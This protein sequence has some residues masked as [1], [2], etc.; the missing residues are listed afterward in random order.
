MTGTTPD[1]ATG[2]TA[3]TDGATPGPLD[4]IRVVDL[5]SV[6]MGPYAARI[7]GDLGAEVVKI[8]PPTGDVMRQLH[9]R[10][11]NGLGALMLNLNRNK[12]SAALDLKSP[13]GHRAALDIIA[14]ADVLITNMRPR[15]LKKLGLTYDDLAEAN[16]RLVYCQAAGFRAD[17]RYADRAAYDEVIQSTSGM[18]DLM[19]RATGKPSY[20]PTVLADKVCGLAIVQGVMAALLARVRTG[21]G[22]RVEVPMADTMFA[23]TLLEHIGGRAFEP[24]HGDVGFPR[25]LAPG[26]EALPTKDGYACILPYSIANVRAFFTEVGRADLH[27]DPR[28]ADRASMSLHIGELYELIGQHTPERTTREWESF[29]ADASIPFAPVLDLDRAGEHEYWAEGGMLAVTDHPTEGLYRLIGSPLAFSDTPTS[30]RRHCPELGQHT[31]EVL[32]E[33]GYTDEQLAAVRTRGAG[34]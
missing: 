20:V 18:V 10:R 29:C 23:F 32:T 19:R 16:P 26:H 14:D 21:R 1:R 17:S 2:S 31:D 34:A 33:L 4:G 30:L 5:A 8:E 25:S 22:Q 15:A 13:A 3:N 28:F 9:K 27:D 7:L 24:P 11:E 6:V 12:R